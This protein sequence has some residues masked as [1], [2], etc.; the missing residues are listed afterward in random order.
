[1]KRQIKTRE[2]VKFMADEFYTNATDS[3]VIGYFSKDVVNLNWEQHLLVMYNFWSDMLL[4]T[5]LYNGT[6]M[7]KY[8][9]LH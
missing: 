3:A 1:M 9:A 7:K 6:P 4:G 5:S 8:F 2:D